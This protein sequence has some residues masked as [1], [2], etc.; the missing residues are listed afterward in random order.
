[1]E[2]FSDLYITNN[3]KIKIMAKNQTME[4][5]RNI[6]AE[7]DDQIRRANNL[8]QIYEIGHGSVIVNDMSE[9]EIKIRI[10]ETENWKYNLEKLRDFVIY[11]A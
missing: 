1:M 3:L 8:I 7:I 2:N 10:D 6:I 11:K 5:A 9:E 4:L